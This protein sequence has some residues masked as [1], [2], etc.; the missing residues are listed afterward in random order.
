MGIKGNPHRFLNGLDCK[1]PKGRNMSWTIPELLSTQ[2]IEE[3]TVV[4]N[5]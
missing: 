4:T 2:D 5:E 1:L 3:K